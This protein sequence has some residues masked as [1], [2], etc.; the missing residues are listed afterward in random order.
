[1]P[2]TQGKSPISTGAK[3]HIKDYGKPSIG[4]SFG[5]G[6]PLEGEPVIPTLHNL[7]QLKG[8]I[9]ET[10]AALFSK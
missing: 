6:Q 4:I 1:V 9:I 7:A 10:F 3:L 2:P 8:G 5:K